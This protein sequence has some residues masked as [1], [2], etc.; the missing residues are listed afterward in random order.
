MMKVIFYSL[1]CLFISCQTHSQE[2]QDDLR[3]EPDYEFCDKLM[4]DYGGGITGGDGC[5][6]IDLKDGRSVFM[7]GD[8]FMGDVIDGIRSGSSKFITGNTFTVINKEGKIE[9]LYSGE[10]SNPSAFIAAEQLSGTYPTW[11]WPGNGFV[12]GDTLHLFMSKFH[13]TGNGIFDFEYLG[14]DYFRL[15]VKSMNVIGMESF[16]AANENDVH[17]GHA[18]LSNQDG[19]YIYG[20]KMDASGIADV[21]VAKAQLVNGR[22]D[23][24]VYWDG[25]QWQADPLK[26]RK[27]I[28][29]Y[30]SI[31]EQFS[32]F[33]LGKKIVLLSQNRLDDVKKI[34]SYIADNP[35]GPFRN[36]RLIY[37]INEPDFDVDGMMIYNAM[38]HPQFKKGNKIL[39]SYNV[40]TH[41]LDKVF[42]K[43]SLYKPRFIWVPVKRIFE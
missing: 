29:L 40:N 22:L 25:S 7:W 4:P 9:T 42:K 3:V 28:G 34:Y 5:I 11:Y 17:Y 23:D 8:S 39:V 26:S 37:T 13:K 16:K 27:L 15:D 19:V 2:I 43:A 36:E 10:I 31:S 1:L 33:L 30:K 32:V 35:A 21:H 38:A 41:D 20:T 14:C 12:E 6:S 24:F 18:V